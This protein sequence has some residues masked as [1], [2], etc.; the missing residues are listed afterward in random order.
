VTFLEKNMERHLHYAVSPPTIKHLGKHLHWILLLIFF[1]LTL[2]AG[3]FVN[4]NTTPAP[5]TQVPRWQ[6]HDFTF[7]SASTPPNPFTVNFSADMSGPNGVKLTLPGFYDGNNTWK[8]RFSPT[9]EGAWSL[10]T[11]SDLSDLDNQEAQFV[12]VANSNAKVHGGLKVDAQNPHHFIYEDGTHW[13]PNGYECNWLWALDATDSKLPVT[14][15]FLDKIAAAGYNF[16]LVNAFAYDTTWR[17]GNTSADDYGPPPFIP[18]EGTYEAPDYSRFNLTYW[19]HF[20]AMVDALYQRGMA[21]HL[22]FKVYNKKV[23]WPENGT[24]E[25]D[26]YYRWIVARYAGYPNMIWDLAKEANYEKSVE[27]K[28]D[29]LKFIRANDPYHHLLTVHTDIAT[30]NAGTYDGLLDF[31]T[32]QYQANI[33]ATMLQNLGRNSWPVINAESGYECGPNGLK[34]KTY[35]SAQSPEE[36]AS[37]IWEARMGGGYTAY[38]YTYT[39]WDVLKPTDTPPGYAYIK[40][41][42]DF[43]NTTQYWLCNPSDSLVSS[44]YCL[45]N[46]GQEYVVYQSQAAPFT[47]KLEGLSTSLKAEWFQPFTGQRIDAGT[48]ENGVVALTPPKELGVGP[49]ALHVGNVSP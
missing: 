34:D 7:T 24:P 36:V 32:D 8:I 6:P 43:F 41:F 20:D 19:Q 46:P 1:C 39:A 2:G 37:R 5:N 27:Y 33:H 9:M 14:Q 4:A 31:R 21:V 3:A 47:L 44:G 42:V 17:S 45:A 28:V 13:F 23:K 40:N 49:V 29:R 25:D 38:Y 30:Y 15:A 12:C 35:N 22:Y 48:L 11:H 10:A 16:V 18:W 26:L